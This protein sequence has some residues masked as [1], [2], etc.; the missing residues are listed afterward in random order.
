MLY[1]QKWDYQ[2]F[3]M[4]YVGTREYPLG[5]MKMSHMMAD[6]Q[7]ELHG[8]ADKLG[9]DRRHFQNKKRPHYDVSKKFKARAISYGAKLVNDRFLIT[10]Q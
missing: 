4:V 2:Y 10:L 7:E 8:M 1:F 5:R 3:K 6:T 9:L